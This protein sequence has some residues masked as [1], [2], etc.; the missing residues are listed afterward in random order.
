M[1]NRNQLQRAAMGALVAAALA[2]GVGQASASVYRFPEA[3]PS[4]LEGRA[5]RV[6]DG[7]G[8]IGGR[9]RLM[10][11]SVR[12]FRD[13]GWEGLQGLRG[14]AKIARRSQ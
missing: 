4:R 6:D 9:V 1:K 3:P 10:L 13:G 14:P 11:S 2:G 8:G 12:I 7:S 5:K